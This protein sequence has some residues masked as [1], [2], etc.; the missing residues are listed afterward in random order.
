MSDAESR[1]LE[2]PRRQ[3]LRGAMLP[4]ITEFAEQDAKGSTPM[5]LFQRMFGGRARKIP[6]P[7]ELE[8]QIEK[9]MHG[10][11]AQTAAHDGIWHIGR[12]DWSVDQEAGTIVFSSPQGIRAVAPVQIIGSYNTDD[13]TW[14]CG[15]GPTHRPPRR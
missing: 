11:Q 8:P 14:R 3:E 7:T 6:Y 12:A 4:I 13:G 10:L 15:H 5:G 9:A 2:P 1:K